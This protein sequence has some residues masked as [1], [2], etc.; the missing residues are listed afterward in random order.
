MSFFCL[1]HWLTFPLA[2]NLHY[3]GNFLQRSVRQEKKCKYNNFLG[4]FIFVLRDMETLYPNKLTFTTCA[5]PALG[6]VHS[7]L[8][9]KIFL[10]PPLELYPVSDEESL[11]QK[12]VGIHNQIILC[13]LE[14]QLACIL[15][16]LVRS[17]T[18]ANWRVDIRIQYYIAIIWLNSSTFE[19]Y[20][21]V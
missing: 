10:L 9:N 14:Y 3:R 2:Y 7:R 19:R 18:W 15:S 21:R 13:L 20:L 6:I 8:S 16:E 1:L 12:N 4:S 5:I 11:Y 17:P